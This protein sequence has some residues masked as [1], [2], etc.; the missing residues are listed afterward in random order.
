MKVTKKTI[1]KLVQQD[2]FLLMLAQTFGAQRIVIK[3]MEW[4]K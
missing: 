3:G 2:S 1:W 4:R